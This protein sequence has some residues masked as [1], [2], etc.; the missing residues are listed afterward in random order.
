MKSSDQAIRKHWSV[1]AQMVSSSFKL[2]AKTE[3]LEAQMHEEMGRHMLQT[4]SQS[5]ARVKQP[6]VSD[7]RQLPLL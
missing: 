2:A 4:L 3:G 1:L 6:T 5:V 7:P